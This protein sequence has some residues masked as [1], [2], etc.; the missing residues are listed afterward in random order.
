MNTQKQSARRTLRAAKIAMVAA[1]LAL[2]MGALT[3]CAGPAPTQVTKDFFEAVKASDTDKITSTYAGTDNVLGDAVSGT[4]DNAELTKVV[5]ETLLPKLK[6]FDYEISNETIEG[7]KATVEAKI[8][9]YAVGD[10]FSGF[11]ADY[12]TQGVTLALSGADETQLA[13]LATGLLDTKLQAMQK[14]YTAT[15]TV[16]LTKVDGAWKVDAIDKEGELVN[17]LSGGL[18][19]TVKNLESV[20]STSAE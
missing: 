3:A 19:D 2:C 15:V 1:V 10:A 17:A 14:T 11:F 4:A 12:M 13:N 7:D 8:T 5:N 20:Y 9:T 18:V 6:E 16:P